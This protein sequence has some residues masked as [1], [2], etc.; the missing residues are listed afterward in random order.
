MIGVDT[1][2]LAGYDIDDA[3]HAQA[4]RQRLAARRLIESGPPRMVS[5]SMDLE[6][7]PVMRGYDSFVQAGA[8]LPQQAA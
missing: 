3:A 4:R 5:K 8:V 7:E 1:S 6:L 2:V